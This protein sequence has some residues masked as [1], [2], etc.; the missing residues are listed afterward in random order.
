MPYRREAETFL[1][2]WRGIERTLETVDPTSQEAARLLEIAAELRAS[3]SVCIERAR[4][5]YSP[6]RRH[7]RSPSTQTG[8]STER[9]PR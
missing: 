7:A 2:A 8:D 1:A 4:A 3:Y 6:E 9:S 5:A